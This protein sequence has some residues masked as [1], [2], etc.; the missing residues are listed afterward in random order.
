ML[1]YHPG[2]SL[3]RRDSPVSIQ[4]YCRVSE[5]FKY[6][7]NCSFLIAV[8][9]QQAR[10]FNLI[11]RAS[12]AAAS[13]IRFSL[14]LVIINDGALRCAAA[15]VIVNRVV[16]TCGGHVCTKTW[17]TAT[18][19]LIKITRWVQRNTAVTI[20]TSLMMNLGVQM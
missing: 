9:A 5:D 18:C 13:D 17:N 12:T 7:S 14:A 8:N 20:I 1:L 2:D 10:L 6:E 16:I 3:K 11:G 15:T 4:S 19:R